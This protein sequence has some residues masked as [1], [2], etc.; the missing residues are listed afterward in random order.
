MVLDTQRNWMKNIYA[1][2]GIGAS[3]RRH[4]DPFSAVPIHWNFLVFFRNLLFQVK[5][6]Q[7]AMRGSWDRNHVAAALVLQQSIQTCL[8]VSPLRVDTILSLPLISVGSFGLS[9]DYKENLTR[10][11]TPARK[12]ND[13]FYYFWNEIQQPFKTSTWESVYIYKKNENS[14]QCLW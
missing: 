2:Q 12:V 9:C 14:E 3:G 6:M 5:I 7:G 10:L 4:P 13:F 11:L 1:V 8:L